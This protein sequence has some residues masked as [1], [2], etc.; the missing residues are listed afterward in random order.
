MDTQSPDVDRFLLALASLQEEALSLN[1]LMFLQRRAKRLLMAR[2]TP[3]LIR[4][5]PQL[6]APVELDQ[7][8]SA[9][10]TTSTSEENYERTEEHQEQDTDE[11]DT[12]SIDAQP[13][14]SRV[15]TTS[16]SLLFHGFNLTSSSPSLSSL[17]RLS[18]ASFQRLGPWTVVI[19]V[20]LGCFTGT[21]FGICT[22]LALRFCLLE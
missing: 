9:A 21:S 7:M 13:G 2:E 3:D 10:A 15:R 1:D 14:T 8:I 20:I 16:P 6:E 19:A 18:S 11:S 12:S 17:S 4:F 5:P 22:A